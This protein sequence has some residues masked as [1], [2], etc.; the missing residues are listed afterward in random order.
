MSSNP[1]WGKREKG[2]FAKCIYTLSRVLLSNIYFTKAK[3]VFFYFVR[4]FIQ[5]NFLKYSI[6]TI[7]NTMDMRI[8]KKRGR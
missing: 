7:V 2:G 4:L 3:T 8:I 6:I 5:P 1:I